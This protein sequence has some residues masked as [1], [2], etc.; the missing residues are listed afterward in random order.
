MELIKLMQTTPLTSDNGIPNCKEFPSI[1]KK[2]N[3]RLRT[4]VFVG[5]SD[6]LEFVIIC[7]SLNS[8]RKNFCSWLRKVLFV[9]VDQMREK[10]Y[11]KRLGKIKRNKIHLTLFSLV[12]AKISA[13]KI[14]TFP[15][16]KSKYKSNS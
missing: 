13:K 15:P 14:V 7:F 10:L 2:L 8:S 5:L 11:S 6:L 1:I 12:F 9:N 3:V 4:N 16:L